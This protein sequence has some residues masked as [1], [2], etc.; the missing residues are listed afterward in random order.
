MFGLLTF[1]E[2]ATRI[3]KPF[4]LNGWDLSTQL[5]VSSAVGIELMKV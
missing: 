4:D 1:T 5:K 2:P 3:H